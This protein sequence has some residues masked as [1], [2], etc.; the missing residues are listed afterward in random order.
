MRLAS[1]NPQGLPADTAL[2]KSQTQQ[3]RELR[4]DVLALHHKGAD[5]ARKARRRHSKRIMRAQAA[6]LLKPIP[7][8]TQVVY[9][10]G[11]TLNNGYERAQG[12]VTRTT[13]IGRIANSAKPVQ[14]RQLQQMTYSKIF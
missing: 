14:S 13:R 8:G 11:S 2:G 10:D 4:Y 9:T 5:K 12:K 1:F 7:P 6:H 3:Y